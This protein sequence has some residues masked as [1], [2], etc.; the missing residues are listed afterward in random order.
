MTSQQMAPG[1]P[2]SPRSALPEATALPPALAAPQLPAGRP[3]AAPSIT[4]VFTAAF[5]A[6]AVA[7]VVN[8]VAAWQN[9][10]RTQDAMVDLASRIDQ[11]GTPRPSA[12]LETELR[13]MRNVATDAGDDAVHAA[14][15][16]TLWSMTVLGALAIGL[17]YYRRRFAS[18]FAHVVTALERVAAGRYEERLV[19]DQR[20]EF[21]MIVRS[22]NRMADALAWRERVQDQMGRLLSA[23]NAPPDDAGVGSFGPALD[24]LAGATGAAALALYQPHY[25]TNEWAPTALRRATAH[26]LSREVVRE[27]IGDAASVI[28]CA[29]G[30][31][32]P[33]RERLRFGD[34]SSPAATGGLALVPLRSRNRLVGLLAVQLAGEPSDSDRTALEHAAPNLAIACEREA[35]HQHT[36]RLAVEV[37]HAA[38]R[39]ESQNAALTKLNDQ[40]ETQHHELSRLNAELDKANRLKDQFLANVSHELRTPLNSVIGFSDLLLSPDSVVGPLTDTQRDYLETIARNGRHLLHLINELLDLSKIAAGRMQLYR[41]RLD[42]EALLREAAASVHAQ[43]EARR[44]TL[45]IDPPGEPVPV[46]A[47]HVRLR[48]VLLNLLSNAIKFTPEGGGVTVVARLED[49]GQRVRVAV[50]DTGIGI[51]PHDQARLFQEFVQLDG[52]PS[53]RYEGSGLGLALSKRL[54]E[55]HGGRIGVKSELGKG[56]TF[57]FTLPRADAQP[58]HGAA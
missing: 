53:R 31:A 16:T 7:V 58:A 44:H 34:A 23:L 46:D 39:L 6:I 49:T 25:D 37:R 48:Q 33:V 1:A 10:R 27:L 2:A 29:G 43:L 35:A 30:G 50:T 18:P 56:S 47:D 28:H 36:R 17:W 54:V 3:R 12:D 4:R 8:R 41:E 57:W 14:S 5:L 19:E 11:V 26:P 13:L 52:G 42:I 55:L 22:V 45:A 32:G 20:G 21:G 38:Q 24:V 40:L 9:A 51:A 15:Q